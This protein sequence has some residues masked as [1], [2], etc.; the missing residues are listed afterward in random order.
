MVFVTAVVPLSA[1]VFGSSL[2]PVFPVC[3]EF[4]ERN[5]DEASTWQWGF[6]AIGAL[7]AEALD[8]SAVS[9]KIAA[10]A[11]NSSS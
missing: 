6:G 9:S 5:G 2:V 11:K 3:A 10:A 8:I 1:V 4:A 7:V